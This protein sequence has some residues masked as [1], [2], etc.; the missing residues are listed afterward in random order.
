MDKPY[1]VFLSYNSEDREAVKQIATYLKDEA[2]LEPWLD[3]W[4]LIPGEPWVSNLELGLRSSK[5]CAVFIGES[6]EGPWNRIE[7]QHALQ[8]HAADASFRSWA[9]DRRLVT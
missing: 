6:G 7:V 5:S 3:M 2:R 8:E 4:H 1:D 9:S